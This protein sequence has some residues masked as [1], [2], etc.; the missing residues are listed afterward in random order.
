MFHK[1]I[2]TILTALFLASATAQAVEYS[3]TIDHGTPGVI[4]SGSKMARLV[5][6]GTGDCSAIPYEVIT[7]GVKSLTGTMDLTT[8]RSM[9]LDLTTLTLSCN[10]E[11][12]VAK[13][14]GSEN[15]S[16]LFQ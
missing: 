15:S 12:I 7:D 13:I 11:G 8:Q 6:I 3:Y 2:L 5:L 1:M 9:P 4:T 14:N 10:K 16:S